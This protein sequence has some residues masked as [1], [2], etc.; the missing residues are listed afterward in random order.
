[1]YFIAVSALTFDPVHSLL[2]VAKISYQRKLLRLYI[3]SFCISKICYVCYVCYA[4][5][6]D[7]QT[8]AYMKHEDTS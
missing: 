2:V 5:Y 8:T 3:F 4:M 1:M 6:E 7:S